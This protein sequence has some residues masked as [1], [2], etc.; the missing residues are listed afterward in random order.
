MTDK[1]GYYLEDLDVGMSDVFT[2]TV[3]EDDIVNFAGLTGDTNPLHLDHSYAE[4]TR[5]KERIAHGML[6]RPPN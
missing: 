6:P 3:T 1:S 2:K 5:F 4:K